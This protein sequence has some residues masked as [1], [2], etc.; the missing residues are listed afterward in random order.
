MCGKAIPYPWYYDIKLSS[1]PVTNLLLYLVGVNVMLV[2][3]VI[4]YRR[5][6]DA[7]TSAGSAKAS[8][9]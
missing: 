2:G 8:I 1:A 5:F 3:L 7:Y 6:I 4:G 9:D